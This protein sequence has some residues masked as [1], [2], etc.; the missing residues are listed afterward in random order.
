MPMDR[1]PKSAADI[2]GM[3]D[4]LY[5]EDT[6][7]F[8]RREPDWAFS[9]GSEHDEIAR[10]AF[11]QFGP[12][13]FAPIFPGCVSAAT[14]EADLV[15]AWLP[16]VGGDE[17]AHGITTSGGSES[18]MLAVHAAVQY[19]KR[20]GQNTLGGEIIAAD[21]AYPGID[22]TAAAYQLKIKRVPLNDALQMDVDAVQEAITDRTLM[23]FASA[24]TF[25]YG[26]ADDIVGLGA[27]AQKEDVWLHVDA[28]IGGFLAPFLR[29]AG[30]DIPPCDLSVDGVRS[31]CADAHKYGYTF[32]AVSMLFYKDRTDFEASGFLVGGPIMFQAT[33]HTL[34]G[35]RSSGAVAAAWAAMHSLGETGFE[36]AAAKI[37]GAVKQICNGIDAMDGVKLYNDPK[38]AIVT[39]FAEGV[40][41]MRLLE[42]M[43]MGDRPW[44][45]SPL[46]R[47]IGAFNMLVAPS[48]VDRI[49][50]FLNDLKTAVAA[51]SLS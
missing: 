35:T 25:H 3:L 28:C 6:A 43:R 19:A 17:T 4:G 8:A 15:N 21:T 12:D 42:Q 24:P 40:D 20:K 16:Y 2:Q 1:E 27:V 37:A 9:A 47:P 50:T 23:I 18:I 41:M 26:T 38:Y 31:I 46:A 13:V 49:D 7:D 5:A 30:V 39:F 32:P 34:T 14:F 10:S 11:N 33:M 44:A 45:L 36:E 48:Y 22:K 51:N 29:R